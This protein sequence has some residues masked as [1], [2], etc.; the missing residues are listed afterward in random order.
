MILAATLLNAAIALLVLWLAGTDSDG[1]ELALR[2][3]ARVSFVWFMLAFVAEPLRQLWPSPATKWLRANR[4]A[5]GVIFGVSMAMH[6]AFISRMFVLHAPERPPMVTDED[7]T[8]GIPG[9]LFVAAMTATSFDVLKR[10]LSARAWA[11]LHRTGLWFVWAIF[12]LCL[13]DSV[14]RKETDHPFSAYYVFIAVL[15]AAL[16]VRIAAARRIARTG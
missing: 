7:F 2:M 3:T 12:F 15:L 16:G 1:T 13:V 5:F 8:I 9:L 14:G 11:R 10:R 4:R 6:V